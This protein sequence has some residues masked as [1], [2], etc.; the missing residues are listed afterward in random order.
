MPDCAAVPPGTPAPRRFRESGSPAPPARPCS[1]AISSAHPGF[2]P[3]EIHCFQMSL[4][5]SSP[6][7]A[8]APSAH[9]AHPSHTDSSRSPVL[10]PE[11]GTPW[12]ALS[13]PAPFDIQP[14]RKECT[15]QVIRISANSC[16][17]LLFQPDHRN[18]VLLREQIPV[19]PH[20]EDLVNLC[21]ADHAA[22]LLSSI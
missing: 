8:A 3:T 19:L 21:F 18:A 4:N 15:P 11:S 6:H 7:T 17:F 16:F 2:P 14:A 1:P 10:S 9:S 12:T 13:G 22:V 5:I 20:A